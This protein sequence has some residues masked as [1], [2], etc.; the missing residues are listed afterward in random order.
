MTSANRPLLDTA[1]VISGLC[2]RDQLPQ[3]TIDA[4]LR[5]RSKPSTG[6]VGKV[7]QVRYEC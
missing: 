3:A 1:C 5:K 4:Y 7:K 2:G 6:A